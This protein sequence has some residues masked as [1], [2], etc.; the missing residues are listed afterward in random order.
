[1]CTIVHTIVS[2]FLPRNTKISNL[3]LFRTSRLLVLGAICPGR[4]EHSSSFFP[5]ILAFLRGII[6]FKFLSVYICGQL[7]FLCALRVFAVNPLILVSCLKHLASCIHSSFSC[8][9]HP[10]SNRFRFMR[11]TEVK[12]SSMDE[13]LLKLFSMSMIV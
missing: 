10:F 9:I 5:V 12:S 3:F 6:S 11:Y 4:G 8:S 7:P 1:M 13:K 2:C